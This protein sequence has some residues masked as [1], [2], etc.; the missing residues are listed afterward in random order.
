[1]PIHALKVWVHELVM[2]IFM[3]EDS[4]KKQVVG[5]VCPI[6]KIS[7]ELFRTNVEKGFQFKELKNKIVQNIHDHFDEFF[8]VLQIEKD[9]LARDSQRVSEQAMTNFEHSSKPCSTK[10]P[11]KEKIK[12]Y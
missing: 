11:Q 1:M 2:V 8:K 4:K 9:E 3:L 10:K 12:V 6:D 5:S 7:D